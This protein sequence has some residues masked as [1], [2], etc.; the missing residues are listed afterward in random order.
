MACRYISFEDAG[1]ALS[2][3]LNKAVED[4]QMVSS[5]PQVQIQLLN[6][7]ID[8]INAELVWEQKN[9]KKIV[10]NSVD[11]TDKAISISSTSNTKIAWVVSLTVSTVTELAKISKIKNITLLNSTQRSS[12]IFDS[13]VKLYSAYP[14][15]NKNFQIWFFLETICEPHSRSLWGG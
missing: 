13:A 11:K 3:V 6:D 2:G 12:P 8:L 1:Y 15:T 9:P 4:V 10:K 14:D 5:S 7:V